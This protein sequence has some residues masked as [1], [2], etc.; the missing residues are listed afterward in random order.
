M[1]LNM[2]MCVYE[3]LKFDLETDK[4]AH[5]VDTSFESIDLLDKLILSLLVCAKQA[6]TIN[7]SKIA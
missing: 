4:I 3:A 2:K 7:A 6:V 5:L 1:F